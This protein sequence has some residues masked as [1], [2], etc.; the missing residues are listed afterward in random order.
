MYEYRNLYIIDFTNVE[1]YFDMHF[2]IRDGLDFPDYYGCNWDAMWDCLTDM[3]GRPINI[4]IL[5]LDIIERKFGNVAKE[6][7]EIFKEFKYDDAD[8]TDEI[9]VS[10]VHGDV[11]VK[12]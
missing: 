2:A 1:T 8:H 12:I 4:E 7:I 11:R 6:L 3:L 5:G 9:N 10:I